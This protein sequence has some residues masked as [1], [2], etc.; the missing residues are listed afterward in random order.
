MEYAI[1][2]EKFCLG[3]E[4]Y[5]FKPVSVVRGIHFKEEKEFLTETGLICEDIFGGIY[6][7]DCY[8]GF[9]TNQEGL[10]KR[11]QKREQ[12]DLLEIYFE[13]LSQVLYF[14]FAN[15]EERLCTISI[16]FSSLEEVYY[17]AINHPM[18]QVE[19]K[20]EKME[21]KEEVEEVEV[22]QDKDSGALIITLPNLKAIRDL[23]SLEDIYRVLDGIMR[24]FD[25]NKEGPIVLGQEIE[26]KETRLEKKNTSLKVNRKK[27][28]SFTLKTLRKEVLKTI[29]GQDEAVS[30]LTRE[31]MINRTSPNARN[32]SHLLI[33]GPTGT[34]KTEMVKTIC[35]LLDLPYFEADA[36]AYTKEGYVGKSVYSMLL[37]LLNAAGGDLEKA[38]KGILVIDE[39]DKKLFGREDDVGGVSVLHS[40][41]KI[42][43]RGM[44]ELDVVDSNKRKTIYFNTQ[45]L[46]IILMGAF[47]DLYE[48][49]LKAKRTPIGFETKTKEKKDTCFTLT[50][51]DLIEGGVPPEFI[52]RIGE[53][54]STHAFSEKEIMHLLTKS[55]ISAL[56]IQQEYFMEVFGVRLQT[57]YGYRQEVARQVLKQ[58]TNA[59]SVKPIVKQTLSFAIEDF[60]N[61]RRAQVLQLTKETVQ[62]PRKYCVK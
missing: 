28:H 12:S 39:I 3:E 7:A 46:T 15:E 36:T 11:Y 41:Y 58:K 45:N 33:T 31:I 29:V 60:L 62:N 18:Q 38:Q 2:F 8:F 48:K 22:G 53:V 13:E 61:G 32:K 17:G 1:Y 51:E 47:E 23:T 43:D 56:K 37:G 5:F 19:E 54:T 50:K 26:P 16:P 59:R 20:D 30:T 10:E 57:T 25:E 34:G 44:I 14:S 24:R 6:N 35:N 27:S 42:L 55:N 4:R 52:G 40:L 49:K 21:E 9:A